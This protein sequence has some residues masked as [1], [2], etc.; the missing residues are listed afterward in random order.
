MGME[1]GGVRDKRTKR[2]SPYPIQYKPNCP[3]ETGRGYGEGLTFFNNAQSGNPGGFTTQDRCQELPTREKGARGEEGGR[4][5][6]GRGRMQG[7][8][9]AAIKRGNRTPRDE[10]EEEE[11]EEEEA[12]PSSSLSPL[13][14][15]LFTTRQR[16]DVKK[17]DGLAASA[18]TAQTVTHATTLQ[19]PVLDTMSDRGFMTAT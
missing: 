7:D 5:E 9:V 12:G 3:A 1:E 6:G 8:M 4:G 13:H 11:E 17:K 15:K 2:D 19:E 16:C 10:E 18:L 14:G